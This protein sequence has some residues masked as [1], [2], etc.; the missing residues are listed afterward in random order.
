M[1]TIL[2]T[3]K[4]I[5]FIYICRCAICLTNY[6]CNKEYTTQKEEQ[7]LNTSST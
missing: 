7:N 2:D 6:A 3:L 1:E 4:L 5:L